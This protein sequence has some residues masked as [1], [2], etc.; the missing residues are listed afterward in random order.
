MTTPNDHQTLTTAQAT[1]RYFDK[2]SAITT[3]LGRVA[4]VMETEGRLSKA[5]VGVLTRYVTALNF[6]FRALGHKYMYSGR[7]NRGGTLTFDK[8]ESGFP[9][10][11]ELMEMASDAA[12]V[13]KHLAGMADIQTLK[14]Q[15]VSKMLT[16]LEV[17]TK[18]QYALSQRMYYEELARGDLFW[19]RNDPV[20]QWV[21]T[22]GDRRRFRL[23]WAVYDGQVNLPTI[24]IMEV[25]D[26][27]KVPLPKDTR[28]WPEVQAHLMA[29]AVGSLKLLTIARGFD[30]DF[31]DLHPKRLRRFHLGP[32]YSSA[33]TKQ[34]GP[35]RLVLDK[36]RA[37][38]GQ[39]WSMVWTVETLQSERAE[40]VKSGWFG[41]VDREIFLLDLIS[42]RA[43]ED[44]GCTELER[45]VIMPQR[46]YQA[47]EEINPPGFGDVRKF[48]VSPGGRVLSYK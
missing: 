23:H 45:S 43:G 42:G 44:I 1:K 10:A 8:R 4:A 3:H 31:D 13:D 5:D 37:P 48:V 47:L 6:T 24:Y 2:F 22:V 32:M 17:P 41:S 26:S 16:D 14:E 35:L 12:Q 38:A 27:G 39:D 28:R 11:S 9:V 21:E 36:A 30:E 18:L 20:A 25:E 19:V 40:Q 46:P 33:F 34:V 29:Q 7:A 15:M